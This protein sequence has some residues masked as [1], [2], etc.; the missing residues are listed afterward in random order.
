MKIAVVSKS[1]LR[2][3]A[4]VVSYR[5]MQ[6]LREQG[7]DARM[8]VCEKLTA[9]PNVIPAGSFW[10]IKRHFITE[11]LRIVS[12]NG[13]SRQNLWQIDPATDG[14]PLANHPWIREADAILLNWVN[15]GMLSTAGLEK[16]L[17]LGKPV[18][19]TMHDKWNMT[20]LCHHTGDCDGF[21]RHCENCPL[22][23]PGKKAEDFTRDAWL[24]K[25]RVYRR[26]N[27]QFVGVSSWVADE[28]RRSS[29]MAGVPLTVIPNAFPAEEWNP[30]R[31]REGKDI[32]AFGAARI[33]DPVKGL[34]H[35][36]SAVRE[37]AARYPEKAA[38]TEFVLFGN[39]KDP[40][41]LDNL[42]SL[43]V[44]VDHRGPLAPSEV[45]ALLEQSKVILSTSSFET[46]PTTL[47]EGQAA[48]AIPISF[49]RGGQRD[50]IDDGQNGYL[51]DYTAD[52]SLSSPQFAD[53]IAEAL[54]RWSPT[55][56]A[57]LH[58]GVRARFAD[59]TVA[60]R[61]LDLINRSLHPERSETFHRVNRM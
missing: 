39:V 18:I 20:A 15:Q 47:I 52:P 31:P 51:I 32:I 44:A 60:R 7:A 53:R 19:S 45:R 22:L 30:L 5:L 16:L 2:G 25:H 41:A 37:F 17:D 59:D 3:G 50:I 10:D 40:H 43:G 42:K 24:R 26:E 6:A 9:D 33:D 14:L 29:L 11:R 21:V 4:A 28:A 34:P 27:L 46:L 54:D 61:Y 35:L 57:A 36:E 48:G 13:W 58:A 8:V 23:V 55:F 38:N 1:D 12:T 49:D 56:A